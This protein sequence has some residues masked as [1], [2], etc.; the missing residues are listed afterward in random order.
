MA[1]KE[2]VAGDP[3]DVLNVYKALQSV[4][5]VM[6]Q[7]STQSKITADIYRQML[8]TLK[9]MGILERDLKLTNIGIETT[10]NRIKMLEQARFKMG[11]ASASLTSKINA[12]YRNLNTLLIK[13]S[14]IQS[15]I[16]AKN[17]QHIANQKTIGHLSGIISTAHSNMLPSLHSILSAWTA[18]ESVIV[19]IAAL[20]AE[21]IKIFGELDTAAFH[22]RQDMGI[23]RKFTADIDKF[24][25]AGA[26][27]MAAMSVSGK[28]MYEA[29]SAL[30]KALF[31]S[32]N[33]TQPLLNTV[34]IISAQLGVSAQASAELLRNLGLVS[35][36]SAEMQKSNLLFVTAL[37]EAA[38][39]PLKDVM[40]DINKSTQS[41]YQFVSRSGLSMIK[42]AV[43]ARRMGTSLESAT[44]TSKSLLSFTQNV[45]D[46]M[47]ASVLLGKSFN[48][49]KARELAYHRNIKG[50]NQEI[51]KIVKE[52][53]FENLDPFQQEAVAKA[54][55]KS[56]AE[57]G[58]MAQAERERVNMVKAMTPLQKEQ[59][60]TF[61]KMMDATNTQAKNYAEIAENQLMTMS[62]Q[63]RLT[64]ISASW[65]RILMELA[66]TFLPI[67]DV[68]LKFIADHMGEIVKGFSAVFGMV[69]LTNKVLSFFGTSV[70][71][72]LTTFAKFTG[73]AKVFNFLRPFLGIGALLGKWIPIIGWIITAIQFLINLF[74]R[75]SKIEFVKGDWLGNIWKGIKAVGG[76]IYDTL[77]QPFVDVY[78]WVKKHLMGS[79]PSEIG[80][81]IVRGIMAVSGMLIDALLFPYTKA[82]EL[83]KKIPFVSKLF[84][85]KDLAGS[86]TPDSVA[87]MTVDRNKPV[88][89]TTKSADVFSNAIATSGDELVKTM[90][91]VLDA[92]NG[93]RDDIKNGTLTANV[94]IDSQKLDSAQGRGL[95][96][97]GALT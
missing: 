75:F 82:W 85:S 80:L 7:N 15:N 39:T 27:S 79:S 16:A 22:F 84:G 45:K 73:L 10:V 60:Q 55:G 14:T 97:K 66:K 29:A 20:I 93:L 47:E 74:A 96:F 87:A 2:Y 9:N 6:R 13:Q 88:V 72:I 68:T 78:N 30:S 69:V 50:L 65:H 11:S 46:E 36:T 61:L 34:A 8:D 41:M 91:S 81:G 76:A 44:N 18:T 42:A 21:M 49:Q 1:E 83:I 90:C 3:A 38:G 37:S 23:T 70:G 94:Y 77:I 63:T 25:R 56:A 58:Q 67:I 26:V 32:N 86:V 52:T 33:V 95:A 4:N 35:R 24:A 40:E 48:L 54:L 51:L 17:Q 31:S 19:V 62:N 57:L 5:V 89:D 59:Y 71:K 64:A 12:E 43:E 53:D 28:T 92:I